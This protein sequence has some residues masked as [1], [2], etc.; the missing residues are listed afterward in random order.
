MGTVNYV[1]HRL[2]RAEYI[3]TPAVL[4][5][6]VWLQIIMIFCDCIH[7][8]YSFMRKTFNHVPEKHMRI[9][10]VTFLR[11]IQDVLLRRTVFKEI[12]Y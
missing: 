3:I 12:L 2:W 1:L 10:A 11:L 8:T 7:A 6:A 5:N 9:I 4:F